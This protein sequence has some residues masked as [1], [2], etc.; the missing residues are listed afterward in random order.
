M[1]P[2]VDVGMLVQE[3]LNYVLDKSQKKLADKI[4]KELEAVQELDESILDMKENYMDHLESVSDFV[5]NQNSVMDALKWTN[6]VLDLTEKLSMN[7]DNM[8]YLSDIE[9]ETL[10]KAVLVLGEKSSDMI[11]DIEKIILDD[12]FSGLTDFLDPN[13]SKLTDNERLT[14]VQVFKGSIGEL[15]RLAKDLEASVKVKIEGRRVDKL[16]ADKMNELF[17]SN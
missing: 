1:K 4:N 2:T 3:G 17:S 7:I 8:E 9:R 5:I 12:G 13:K 14:R 11:Y 15:K 10:D 6:G 16:G